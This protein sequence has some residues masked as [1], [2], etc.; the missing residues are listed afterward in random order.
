MNTAQTAS[1]APSEDRG[2][3]SLIGRTFSAVIFDMDGTLI[4]STAA[5]LRSWQRWAREYGVGPKDMVAHHGVP[6]AAVVRAVLPPALQDEASRRIEELE[7]LDVDGVVVLPGAAEALA[8]LGST[9]AAIATSCTDVL[10]AARIGASGLQVPDVVVTA[11][12][13]TQGK[14]HPDPFLLAAERLGVDPSDCLVVED[15]PMGLQAARVAGCATLALTTTTPVADLVA[16]AVV[17]TLADVHFVRSG[18]Q[19]TVVAAVS[20]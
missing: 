1:A 9:H 7:V 4:D 13:V 2:L 12:Q 11:D 19:V 14:P 17:S 18:G 20:G 10:A 5:V 3:G 16:D 8:A 6:S 15:A